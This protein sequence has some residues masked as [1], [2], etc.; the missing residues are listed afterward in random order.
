MLT[1]DARAEMWNVDMVLNEYGSGPFVPESVEIG[2][3]VI[4][5]HTDTITAASFS[6]DGTALAT[7]SADGNVKFFQVKKAFYRRRCFNH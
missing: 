2:R 5:D 6:P 4:T 1:H 7:A 3:K